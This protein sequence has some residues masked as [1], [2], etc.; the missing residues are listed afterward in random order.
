MINDVLTVIAFVGF[1][2]E[3]VLNSNIPSRLLGVV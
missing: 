3:I 2:L 1:L